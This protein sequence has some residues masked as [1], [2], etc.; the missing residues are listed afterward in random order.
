MDKGRTALHEAAGHGREE[1]V[2]V[3]LKRGANVGSKDYEGRTPFQLA[4]VGGHKA[5]V[6]L[7]SE[8]GARGVQYYMIPT[9]TSSLCLPW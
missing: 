4:S 3:L 5:T 8:Y 1:V 2:R 9:S 6:K 7:L